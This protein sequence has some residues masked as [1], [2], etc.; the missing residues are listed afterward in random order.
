MRS[1]GS[2]RRR[3]VAVGVGASLATLLAVSTLAVAYK[4]PLDPKG[5]HVP[6]KVTCTTNLRGSGTLK[7]GSPDAIRSTITEDL[8]LTHK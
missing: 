8:T 4:T 1:A 7:G 6:Q 3:T 2:C 5:A